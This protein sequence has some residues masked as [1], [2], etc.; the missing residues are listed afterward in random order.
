VQ[1]LNKL[2]ELDILLTTLGTQQTKHSGRTLKKHLWGTFKIL[3]D[4]GYPK[5]VCLGGLFH[6]IYGT[7]F[8]NTQTTL[9]RELVKSAIGEQAE[10]YAY[11]FS[12]LSRPEC[13]KVNGN[14]LPTRNNTEIEV[15][16]QDQQ[17][18]KAIEDANLEEQ[19]A[20]NNSLDFDKY[21]IILD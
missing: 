10:Y 1:E 16:E 7:N 17:A 12:N 11:V 2:H 19:R 5:E 20:R 13:W 15:L 9:D 4:K 8:F 18:L 6:S 3:A 14:K 21:I